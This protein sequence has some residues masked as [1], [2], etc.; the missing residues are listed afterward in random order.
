MR[1]LHLVQLCAAKLSCLSPVLQLYLLVLGKQEHPD[2]KEKNQGLLHSSQECI[3][4]ISE[5]VT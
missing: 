1:D 3:W 2:S 4:T 5:T